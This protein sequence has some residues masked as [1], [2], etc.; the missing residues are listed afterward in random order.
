MTIQLKMRNKEPVL[1]QLCVIETLPQQDPVSHVLNESL[2][3]GLILEPDTVANLVAQG[4]A[5]LLRHPFG[6]THCSHTTRLSASDLTEFRV[7][8][9]VQ[10]LS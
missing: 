7:T 2:L 5:H 9:F 8:G 4:H 10:V 3:A 1:F 6:H